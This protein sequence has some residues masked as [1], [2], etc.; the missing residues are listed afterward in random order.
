M[1]YTKIIQRFKGWCSFLL[2]VFLSV[3][4]IKSQLYISYGV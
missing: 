4:L 1:V 2:Q 3:E